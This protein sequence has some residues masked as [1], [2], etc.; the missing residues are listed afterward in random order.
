MSVVILIGRIL[1][2]LIFVGSGSAGH[3]MQTEGTAGYAESRGVP[4]SKVLTQLSGVLIF[5]GGAGIILGIWADLAALGLVA[6]S[7]ISGFMVHHFWTDQDPTTKQLEMSMF[8]KN[9][10][11]AGGGLILFGFLAAA[12]DGVDLMITDPLFDLDF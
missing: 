7:L 5:V 9:L 1:F 6:Y 10:S 4:S 3:L 2:A 8:M 12:G 11:I